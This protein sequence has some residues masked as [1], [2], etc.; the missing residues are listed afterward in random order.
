[1][2]INSSIE[3]DAPAEEVWNYIADFSHYPEFLV[4]LTRWETVGERTSGLGARFRFLIRIGAADVGGLIEV[5]EWH[6]PTDMAFTSV[7]GIDNRGRW[8][9]RPG[10]QGMT[11]VEFRWA[12]GVA[13][14]GI[15][16]VIAERLAAPTLRRRLRRSL[17]ELKLILEGSADR[18]MPV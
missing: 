13:G 2:R 14:S 17:A 16:G 10:R 15:G 7:T 6:P 9:I 18:L 11:K 1:M 3:I 4:G 12:Y 8:R 5:V